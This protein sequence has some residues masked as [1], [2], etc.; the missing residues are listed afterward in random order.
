M[1]YGEL[2]GIWVAKYE[3]SSNTT[4][5]D[6]NYAGGED[7]KLKVQVKPCVQSWR[8]ISTNTIF[9]VCRRM[10]NAGEVLAG[11]SV[12][13]HMM[14]N[15]EWGAV[16]ILSQSKYGIFNPE[17]S[18][19]INGDKTYQIWNNPNGYNSYKNVYTG[20]VGNEKDAKN[21]YNATSSPAGVELYNTMV[22]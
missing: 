22:V 19:G 16:A 3:A 7:A 9:T 21:P 8:S 18:T 14:K 2:E 13:S 4:T 12:D 11:A 6:E 1:D 20:Y 15:M 10:T 17:S 5:P